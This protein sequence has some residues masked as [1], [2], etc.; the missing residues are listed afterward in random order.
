MKLRTL[1][2]IKTLRGER[3]VLRL[4]LNVPMKGSSIVEDYKIMSALP[5]L[6]HLQSLPIIIISHLGEPVAKS[7]NFFFDKRFSLSPVVKRLQKYCSGRVFLASGSWADIQKQAANLKP[8]EIMVLENVRFW[9]GEITN[10]LDFA[11]QLALLGTIYVNDAFAVCHR[12][13]ASVAGITKYVPSYAGPLLE[14]EISNLVKV[15]NR[16]LVVLVFG[17]AKVSDKLPL[18]K[19][20]LPRAKAIL[21][22]GGIAN[23]FLKVRGAGIGQSYYEAPSLSAARKLHSAKIMVPSDVVV[24]S[25]K[26][27]RISNIDSVGK[28]EI[29][30][31]IG[32]ETAKRYSKYL[33]TAKTIIWNG[34]VGL[35]E[36]T[37]F[38]KGTNTIA[39]AIA[40]ATK[41]GAF[42]VVGG[43]E[44]VEAIRI[45]KFSQTV[46]W[47]STGGGATLHFLS[48]QSL[49]GLQGLRK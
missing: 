29:I 18:I 19:K 8:G 26:K 36:K 41:K 46:S 47:V 25:G 17:G 40:Q 35:F 16:R 21:V 45:M 33:E 49:P 2:G 12:K 6:R 9:L 30:Y 31:D 42:S 39:K 4:D 27:I 10:N 7:R 5:T 48:G 13:H 1:P 11:K 28:K 15:S 3:V 24:Q 34:P 43:G 14:K 23:A 44:T 22:G 32:P 20:F 37:E 38:R